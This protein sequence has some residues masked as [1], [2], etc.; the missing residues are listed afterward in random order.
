[1]L[2]SSNSLL[3]NYRLLVGEKPEEWRKEFAKQLDD[4]DLGI[5]WSEWTIEI[6][7][8]GS[9][10]FGESETVANINCIYDGEESNEVMAT[11]AQEWAKNFGESI[12]NELRNVQDLEELISQ[13]LTRLGSPLY[14]DNHSYRSMIDLTRAEF[15]ELQIKILL[16]LRKNNPER[17]F[18]I[19]EFLVAWIKYGDSASQEGF[20][21]MLNS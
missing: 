18:S 15:N 13:E 9:E 12:A 6:L 5:D 14:F 10:Q 21:D 11:K 17:H 2:T 20:K 19:R 3:T 7:T 8:M 16:D 4:L 1:M